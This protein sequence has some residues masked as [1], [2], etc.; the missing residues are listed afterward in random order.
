MNKFLTIVSFLSIALISNAQTEIENVNTTVSKNE[1]KSQIYFLA[2]DE[3]RGRETGSP[4]I[5][6]AAAYLA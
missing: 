5:D 3:L 4:E 2:S 1:I 6:I